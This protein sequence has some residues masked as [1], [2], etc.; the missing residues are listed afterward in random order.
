MD[1]FHRTIHL[2]SSTGHRQ[3]LRLPLHNNDN[4]VHVQGPNGFYKGK[5]KDSIWC[6]HRLCLEALKDSNTTYQ[7]DDKISYCQFDHTYHDRRSIQGVMVR[8]NVTLTDD[9]YGIIHEENIKALLIFGYKLQIFT[10]RSFILNFYV[11]QLESILLK[12]LDHV[13]YLHIRVSE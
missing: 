2:K 10:S 3:T 11:C 5:D 12:E 1:L 9:A 13:L 4:K 8:D 6:Q 7:C